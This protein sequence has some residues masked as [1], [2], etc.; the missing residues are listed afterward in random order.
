MFNIIQQR[1]TTTAHRAEREITMT[2]INYYNYKELREKALS[3]DATQEDINSL[4]EWFEQ[5]GDEYWNGEYYN[6]DDGVRVYPIV[7][8]V[9]EDEY[10]I[11]GYEIR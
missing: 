11:T 1:K 4:G 6:A 5:Y 3:A 10:E 2:Y 9:D 8:E 7:K